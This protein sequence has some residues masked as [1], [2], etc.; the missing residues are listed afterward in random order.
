V[1]HLTIF[2]FHHAE[3]LLGHKPNVLQRLQ[4]NVAKDQPCGNPVLDWYARGLT[5][6]L[7]DYS[8]FLTRSLPT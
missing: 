2:F 3:D 4:R 7:W 1:A 8:L 6:R 5:P